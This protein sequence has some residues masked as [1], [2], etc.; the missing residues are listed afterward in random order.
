MPH[1]AEE[2]PNT[3]RSRHQET[4]ISDQIAAEAFILQLDHDGLSTMTEILDQ[5]CSV[6]TRYVESVRLVM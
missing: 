4:I 6:S 3:A 5:L 2:L 1:H